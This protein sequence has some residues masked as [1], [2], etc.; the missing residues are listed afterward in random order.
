MPYTS[1]IEGLY[2][3]HRSQILSITPCHFHKY[4]PMQAHRLVDP[5][6]FYMEKCFSDNYL[7]LS[8]KLFFFIRKVDNLSMTGKDQIFRSDEDF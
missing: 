7:Y 1:W 6:Y 5:H 2:N 8:C 3:F 4:F